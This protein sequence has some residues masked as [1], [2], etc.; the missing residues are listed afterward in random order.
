MN[1]QERIQS[2]RQLMKERHIDMYYIPNEDDHMS[3]EYTADYYKCKSYM[4]GFSGEAGCMIVTQSFAGLW[5]DGRYFT[6]AE[7]ELKGSGVELMRL[8]QAGVLD[9]LPYMVQNLQEGETLGYDGNV[10]SCGTTAYLTKALKDRHVH[11][12]T[13]ED[14]VGMVWKDR[15]SLP[16]EKLFVLDEKWVQESASQRIERVRGEM[17]KKQADVLILTTL[18]EPCWM[19]DIRGNDI[20]CTPVAYAYA[21]VTS[22]SVRYYVSLDKVTEEVR[23]HLEKAGV[24]ILPYEAI[25]QDLKKMENKKIWC[26]I[27]TLNTTLYGALCDHHNVILNGPS[28]VVMFKAVKNSAEI[29]HTLEAHKKDGV[30]MVRFIRWIKE[31]VGKGDM[32]EVSAQ[33]HLYAL[34]AQQENYIEPSF[35][36]ISAYQENAAMMHYTATEEKYSMISPKGFLL[37]DSGGTYKDGTTDITRTIACGPLTEEEKKLYTLVLKG[38]LDLANARFLKGTTGNNLDILARRPMWNLCIDYQCGTGHGVGHVLGVHE[39]PNGIRWGLPTPER[40]SAVLEE[41]MIVTDEPGIYLPHK[42]GIRI[43]NELLV[44]PVETNFYGQWLQFQNLTYCPYDLDAIDT[45]YLE[46]EN[47]REINTYHAHVYATL[48]PYLNEEERAWLKQATR[49]ISK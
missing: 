9:P 23:N 19:L 48:A 2:L 25:A 1:V 24:T 44:V 14:L 8:K 17:V 46:E 20:P 7:M 45:R 43:E 30:A 33:N 38:H 27:S 6:Q 12:H 11:L 26:D 31:N 21:L 22:E 5:T 4:S 34:R 47:I 49:E 15:P 10:V 3:N 42:L 29:Q 37:V 28:P 35:T 18:E 32:S 13:E 40:P 39:G 36:T 16:K 41:G